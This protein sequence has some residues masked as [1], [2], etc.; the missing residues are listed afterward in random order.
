VSQRLGFPLSLEGLEKVYQGTVPGAQARVV[1]PRI[2]EGMFGYDISWRDHVGEEIAHVSRF[3]GKRSDNSLELARCGAYVRQD[4]RGEALSQ[5]VMQREIEF[6]RKA[7]SHPQSIITIM[8]GDFQMGDQS[9]K[10]G[11]YT[12]AR[13]GFDFNDQPSELPLAY[14]P[15][16]SDDD[17]SKSNR[18]L[19]QEK[20][21][22]WV[23]GLFTGEAQQSLLDLA[24][25][26]EHPWQ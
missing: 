13:F 23:E 19:L 9:E 10:L 21:R 25:H 6:L 15:R 17:G 3:L 24:P 26:L 14:P 4:A 5:K 7:S 16:S 11:A 2:E 22:G 8:A 12:W 18:Q 20:F 1:N